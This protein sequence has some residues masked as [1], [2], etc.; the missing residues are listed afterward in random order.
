MHIMGQHMAEQKGKGHWDFIYRDI[1]YSG[2]LVVD[3][4][5]HRMH[6]NEVVSIS[7]PK[8]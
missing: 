5:S 8:P 6:N 7:L 2:F 4:H 1:Q 3:N